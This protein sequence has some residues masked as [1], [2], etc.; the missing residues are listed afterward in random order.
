[1]NRLQTPNSGRRQ[2]SARWLIIGLL[3]GLLCGILFWSFFGPGGR[4]GAAVGASGNK[5]VYARG[6]AEGTRL[7]RQGQEGKALACFRRLS[8]TYP[9]RPAA[10]NNLAAIYAL[11]GELTPARE[12]LVKALK[13]SPGYATIYANLGV[14]YAE[15]ARDSYGKALR[16][17]AQVNPPKLRLLATPVSPGVAT[18]LSARPRVAVSRNQRPARA[19]SKVS[20]VKSESLASVSAPAHAGN[21]AGGAVLGNVLP[22]LSSKQS[23]G[24]AR[25]AATGTVNAKVAKAPLSSQDKSLSGQDRK[26]KGPSSPPAGQVSSSRQAP[27]VPTP[28]V[29]PA[30]GDDARILAVLLHWAESW[31]AQ[32]VH[33][34]LAAYSQTYHPAGS[35]SQHN[36][37]VLRRRRLTRPK[38][39]KVTLS[40]IR[41]EHTGEDTVRVVLVQDYRSDRYRDR[42]RKAITLVREDGRWQIVTEQTLETL[43]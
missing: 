16:L 37:E 12:A 3:T 38:W 22:K 5:R 40:H 14:V 27:P 20:A 7:L 18:P 33:A 24:G 34:Y 13:T 42:T 30:A 6:L 32:D 1:M 21:A 23:S 26:G 43:R 2:Q 35:R 10:Y 15:I 36:W 28:K 39:I 4:F 41:I 17:G 11:R 31:S 25:P 29:S 9:D 19:G 8:R